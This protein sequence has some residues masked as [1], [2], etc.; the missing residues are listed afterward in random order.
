[1]IKAALYIRVSTAEQN[2][3][4]YSV[5]EQRERLIAYCKA[6]NYTIYDIYIDG[7]YTGSNLDRP[8]MQKLKAD[9]GNFDMVLVYKLDRLSRS[10][11]DILDLIENTFL[12]AGVDFVSMSEAFDTSTPFGR[13]MIGI[14]G[15]FAQLEREQ[16][17]E[18]M[19]M[20]RK[21][22][23]KEGKYHGGNSPPIGYDYV[24]GKLVPN[25]YEAEQI[26]VL[27]QM[28]ANNKS[29]KDILE[30]LGSAGYRTRYGEWATNTSS[31]ISRTLR[32][33]VYI[34]TVKFDDVIYE[35]AHEPLVSKE[36]FEK[37]NSIRSKR[38]DTYG[39]NPFTRTTMLSGLIWC[40]KC[41]ARYGTTISRHKK[42]GEQVTSQNRYHSCYSR[43]F[44]R[45]KMA[46]VKGC[47]NKNWRL[48][49]LEAVIDEEIRKII[50][51]EGHFEKMFGAVVEIQPNTMTGSEKRVAEIDKQ[52]TK[53]MDLY[54]I[55]SV[56]FD[57]LSSK[58]NELHKE[59]NVLQAQ[60]N[61]AS[62]DKPDTS[63]NAHEFRTLI[64]NMV[65]IWDVADAEQKRLLISSL[66]RKIMIDNEE[67]S[68]EWTFHS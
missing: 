54:T 53:L 43:S 5:G 52:I 22:R 58:M 51:E 2:E 57:V 36:L 50:F 68:I 37:A 31:R 63:I 32:N 40:A 15:V 13:A 64:N 61:K 14:L 35:N 66:I 45:S 1:M 55:D 19:T 3:S 10:Q 12:P 46:K 21:A 30:A 6:K 23:A 48:D 29:N 16:I 47:K 67:V 4:G 17:K 42:P 39:K 7:G 28:A 9:I 24:D 11:F 25:E 65:D 60:I 56:P 38:Q 34:G 27:F 44:P 62:E 59:K 49:S 20:G 41:G 8:A 26:K 18:R 33:D